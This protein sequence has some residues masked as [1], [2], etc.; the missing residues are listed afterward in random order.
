MM[1]EAVLANQ[2]TGLGR[3]D[4]RD[5]WWLG[6]LVTGL[7][8]AA[9]VVYSTFRV[10]Y[11]AQYVV[12]RPDSAYILSP[13]YSPLLVLPWLPAWSLLRRRWHAS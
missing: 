9:F 4:R 6:P 1:A 8:L 11:N 10:F 3:T 2:E 12:D 5:L 13:F 7:V